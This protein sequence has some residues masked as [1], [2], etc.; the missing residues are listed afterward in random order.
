MNQLYTLFTNT[1]RFNV[2]EKYRYTQC[3][4]NLIDRINN[5]IQKL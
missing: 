4:S 5:A 3:T 1:N 2:L